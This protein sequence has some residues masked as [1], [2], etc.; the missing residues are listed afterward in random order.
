MGKCKN[1]PMWGVSEAVRDMDVPNGGTQSISH[2]GVTRLQGVAKNGYDMTKPKVL[3]S[4]RTSYSYFGWLLEPPELGIGGIALKNASILFPS[5][6]PI[7]CPSGILPALIASII[8]WTIAVQ[9]A[10]PTVVQA[11]LMVSAVIADP[12]EGG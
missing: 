8:S 3:L 4:S 2:R 1:A 5:N 10:M 9:S 11:F 7:A 6:L 12:P